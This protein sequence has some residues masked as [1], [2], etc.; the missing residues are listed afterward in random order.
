MP[1]RNHGHRLRCR[2]A[3]ACAAIL[4]AFGAVLPGCDRVPSSAKTSHAAISSPSLDGNQA[5]IEGFAVRIEGAQHDNWVDS[6]GAPCAGR[7]W[8]G[9]VVRI[10]SAEPALLTVFD[11][12]S[13]DGQLAGMA[14]VR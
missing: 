2:K 5:H 6:T 12:P 13:A 4:I 3:Q 11:M 9:E 1:E 14:P 10:T 7:Q 8:G